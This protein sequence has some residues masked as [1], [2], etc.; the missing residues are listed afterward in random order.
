MIQIACVSVLGGWQ[1]VVAQTEI[2]FGPVF[3]RL[4]D[5]WDWQRENLFQPQEN[6]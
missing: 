3:N 5:L 1:T 2:H 4:E 6:A